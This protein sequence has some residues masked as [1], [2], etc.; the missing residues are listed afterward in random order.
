MHKN[1]SAVN[2]YFFIKIILNS[3]LIFIFHKFK[4]NDCVCASSFSQTISLAAEWG[5]RKIPFKELI[6][7]DGSVCFFTI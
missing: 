7:S 3:S 4:I 1:S 5:K 6:F 2:I